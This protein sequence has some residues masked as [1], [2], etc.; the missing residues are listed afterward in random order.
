MS[1]VNQEGVCFESE[2]YEPLIVVSVGFPEFYRYKVCKT[3][4]G[5]YYLKLVARKGMVF[6][7]E[8]L[9]RLE[10]IMHKME[11]VYGCKITLKQNRAKGTVTISQGWDVE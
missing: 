4:N 9:A 2:H 6:T 7:P 1:Q 8:N 11:S 3:R 10:R 5:R